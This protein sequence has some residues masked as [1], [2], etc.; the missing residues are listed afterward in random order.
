MPLSC[1]FSSCQYVSSDP[2]FNRAANILSAH[3]RS[4]HRRAILPTHVLESHGLALCQICH[5]YWG[6]QNGINHHLVKHRGEQSIYV[7]PSSELPSPPL[8]HLPPPGFRISPIHALAPVRLSYAS[9]VAAG[10]SKQ[11]EAK[12]SLAESTR[13]AVADAAPSIIPPPAP[14]TSEESKSCLICHGGLSSLPELPVTTSNHSPTTLLSWRSLVSSL[15]H[16]GVV[17]PRYHLPS[18]QGSYYFP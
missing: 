17:F 14:S 18:M 1:P 9:A 7:S 6:R 12:I 8:S 3:I 13:A 11:R 15:L 2:Q 4:S 16:L 10:E 5:T